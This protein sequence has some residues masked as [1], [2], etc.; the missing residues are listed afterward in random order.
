MKAAC[1]KCATLEAPPPTPEVPTTTPVPTT[2]DQSQ[3]APLAD[4]ENSIY[5]NQPQPFDPEK[6]HQA[7]LAFRPQAQSP[8]PGPGGYPNR[9]FAG[10][11]GFG[12]PGFYQGYGAPPAMY[13]PGGYP[14][15]VPFAGVPYS[16]PFAAPQFLG[17]SRISVSSLE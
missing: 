8:Y 13:Y 9:P 1:A 3:M 5:A 10:S 2:K 7:I 16:F 17:S 11:S 12:G 6:L 15:H 4:P 14:Q